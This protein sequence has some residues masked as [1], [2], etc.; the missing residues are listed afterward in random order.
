MGIKMKSKT[1]TIPFRS[2][3]AVCKEIQELPPGEW[4][5]TIKEH[6]K[7]R[8]IKMNSLLW[9]WINLVKDWHLEHEGKFYT[10]DQ[11]KDGFQK[12]FLDMELV[13]TP[14]GSTVKPQGT[15]TLKVKEFAEFLEKIEMYCVTEL[16]LI[17]PRPDDLYWASM[18]I[19][20]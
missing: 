19:K 17:L 3:Q 9:L 13:E 10:S 20:R 18:G 12:L 15:S 5:V 6:K 7:N 11:I 16:E 2:K 4:D 8:S 1:F 14:F